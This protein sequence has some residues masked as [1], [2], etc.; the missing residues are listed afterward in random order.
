MQKTD[1]K[2]DTH[3]RY[4]NIKITNLE[5]KLVP[6]SYN[7]TRVDNIIDDNLSNWEVAV[8]RF[9]IPSHSIPIFIF[10]NNLYYLTLTDILGVDHTFPIVFVPITN[11]ATF[12][13]NYIFSYNQWVELINTTFTTA[14][15]DI[16]AISR[17]VVPPFVLYN[18]ETQLFSV[19]GTSEYASTYNEAGKTQI[20]FN[21][22]LI[23]KLDSSSLQGFYQ[24]INN[25]KY[26]NIYIKAHGSNLITAGP[27][28][29][30]NCS[31]AVA[32]TA[33]FQMTQEFKALFVLSDFDTLLLKCAKLPVVSE[34]NSSAIGSSD[35]FINM[36]TDFEPTFDNNFNNHSDFQYNPQIYRWTSLSS[37]SNLRDMDLSV[38][39]RDIEGTVR[40]INLGPNQQAT[41]KLVF[42]KKFHLD[43]LLK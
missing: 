37:N 43:K 17:P 2:S 26:F 38:F 6:V 1:R 28:T 8:A 40:Q 11:V 16:P 36:M 42:K 21:S 13:E 7:E 27:T 31:P 5:N 19:Y 24:A 29:I 3:Y 33:Y 25:V 41:L 18:S 30:L 35:Q 20:W 22:Y 12:N 32:M 39:W 14:W 23:E 9:R 10:K 15:N 34:Y 4:Y